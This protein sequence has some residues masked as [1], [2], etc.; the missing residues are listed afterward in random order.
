MT[1][2]TDEAEPRLVN[3]MSGISEAVRAL[4]VAIEEVD[5]A[6]RELDQRVRIEFGVN[7][8]DLAALQYV[9]RLT[10][11]ARP[12]RAS[13]IARRFEMSSGS[14][15]EVVNRLERAQ[16]LSRVRDPDDGRNRILRLTEAAAGRLNELVGDVRSNLNDLLLGISDEEEARLIELLNSVRD[17][18][19]G[20]S[21][22]DGA[23]ADVDT[24]KRTAPTP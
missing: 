10:R 14:A 13:D 20:L 8:T 5:D 1:D 19:R 16:L 9:D 17:I 11:R 24:E 22:Q 3:D 12:A 2:S 23:P 15:T 7:S 6:E 18:F 4:V 21:S